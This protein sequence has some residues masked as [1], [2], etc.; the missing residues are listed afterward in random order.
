MIHSD[1]KSGS[2]LLDAERNAKISNLELASIEWK[3]EQLN[4]NMSNENMVALQCGQD[5]DGQRVIE[6]LE[7]ALEVPTVINSDILS[8]V[9]D[10]DNYQDAIC[11]HHE[12]HEMH[13]DVQPNCIVDLDA[14]YTSDSNIIPYDQYVKEN[15]ETVV[16]SNVS[17]IPNDAYMMILNEMQEQTAKGT[18][19]NEQ[20]KV[21]NA[22]LTAELA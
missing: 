14:E 6:R 7:N 19:T 15:A 13:D 4:G 17:S 22:S 9:Q 11:E 18:S 3:R 21:V 20:N 2:I 10:H 1:I 12:V 5:K 8:E 16:Q